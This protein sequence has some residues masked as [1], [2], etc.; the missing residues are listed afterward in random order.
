MRSGF[1]EPLQQLDRTH[2]LWR[3]RKLV[4]FGGCDY[5]RL[6]FHPRVI[7]AAQAAI[8]K[9]GLNVAASRRTTGNHVLYEDLEAATRRFFSAE[10][11]ILVSNGYLTNIAVAQG[12]RGA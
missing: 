10:R 8:K 1:A 5:L 7:R 2:V 11:A 12:L 9:Y 4:Y 6:S 3:G